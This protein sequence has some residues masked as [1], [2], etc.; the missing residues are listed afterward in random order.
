MTPPI[1]LTLSHF[2][3]GGKPLVTLRPLFRNSGEGQGEG[4]AA[5]G[6]P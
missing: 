1:T 6:R 2:R 3:E 5:L 4:L